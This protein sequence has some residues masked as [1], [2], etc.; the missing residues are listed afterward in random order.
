LTAHPQI[1]HGTIRI[2]FTCDEEIG[3]GVDHLDLEKLGAHVAYTL[4]GS[5]TGEIDG[6]TFS[7]DLAV[8]KVTGINIHP[9]IA[10]SRMI[11]AIRLAGMLLDRLPRQAL[12]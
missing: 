6:E 3:H 5:G 11:N 10:K 12:S 9:S 1:A 8:V 4:D 7:A 2:C